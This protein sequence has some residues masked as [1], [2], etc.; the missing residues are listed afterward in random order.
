[1]ETIKSFPSGKAADPDGF[2]C[3]FYKA[4]HKTLAPLLLRMIKDM[5]ENK[6]SLY[7]A[8]ICLLLKKKVRRT[9][10]LGITGPLLSSVLT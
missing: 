8:N 2:G 10:S 6:T 1:M 7:E 9:P 4:F 3:E 5:T